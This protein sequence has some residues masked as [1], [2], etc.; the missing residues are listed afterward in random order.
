M[1]LEDI[2]WVVVVVDIIAVQNLIRF[3]G[4]DNRTSQL[5]A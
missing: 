1:I 3:L 4:E 2:L 5:V